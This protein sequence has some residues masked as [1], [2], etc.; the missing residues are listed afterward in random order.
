M[1]ISPPSSTVS[2][3]V[4]HVAL[5]GEERFAYAVT[6][7]GNT[8]WGARVLS[9]YSG[10]TYASPSLAIEPK[11]RV[12]LDDMWP[13]AVHLL[14]PTF[15]RKLPNGGQTLL[16][17]RVFD[18]RNVVAMEDLSDLSMEFERGPDG[19]Y[20]TGT[21][22]PEPPCPWEHGYEDSNLVLDSCN[23]VHAVLNR[24]A[25]L[26]IGYLNGVGADWELELVPEFG[27][28]NWRGGPEIGINADGSIEVV[29]LSTVDLTTGE[30]RLRH[31]T[32]P[33]LAHLTE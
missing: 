12:F 20:L 27:A 19:Q 5:G 30:T 28:G 29:G 17:Q 13:D 2:P 24:G 25:E 31:L 10:Y 6:W 8:G 4:L 32:K 9:T 33:C 7:V 15:E 23:R 22:C 3:P 18:D 26:P 11:A 21:S 16:Y 14:I 1:S